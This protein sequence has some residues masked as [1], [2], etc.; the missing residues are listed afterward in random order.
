M[1]TS[2][3]T[4]HLWTAALLVTATLLFSPRLWAEPGP[5]TESFP[6]D[7]S[8]FVSNGA[9]P[10]FILQPGYEQTYDGVEDG[11]E[12][13]LTITVTNQTKKVDGVTTRVVIERESQ[14][15]ELVEVSYNYF[16]LHKPTNSV[17]Y[18]GEQVDM[19][20]KGKV[21][22]H[23]GSWLAGVKGAKPGLMMPGLPLLGARYAQEV[24]PGTAMDR[25]EIIR[26][27]ETL[28]TPMGE[29]KNCLKTEE[30]TPLEPGSKEY[31]VYAPGIGLIQDGALKLVKVTRQGA[32]SK[33]AVR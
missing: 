11:E 32:G 20:A 5:F 19:Y 27:S 31:K 25:A 10:F 9:N 1:N 33:R 16:A 22:N 4:G 30:T 12:V 3:K 7:K 14:D 15:G 17:F 23:G 13:H 28:K 21:T 26:L 8:A 2:R 6:V 24:A 29:F 18:F